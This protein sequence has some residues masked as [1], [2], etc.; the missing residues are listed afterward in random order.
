[1]AV[2]R[3]TAIRELPHTDLRILDFEDGN[4]VLW[5]ESKHFATTSAYLEIGPPLN[6]ADLANAPSCVVSIRSAGAD[7]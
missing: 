2:R 3:I 1:M 5:D 6:V 7:R 4:G